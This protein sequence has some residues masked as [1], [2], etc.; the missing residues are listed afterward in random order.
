MSNRFYVEGE[1]RGEKVRDLFSRVAPRY[2]FINDLQSFGLH[3]V[4]KARLTRLAQ[5][6]P[7]EQALDVCCGTGDIAFSLAQAGAHVTALDFSDA[8]LEVAKARARRKLPLRVNFQQGDAQHLPFP[9]NSFDVVSIGYG[10]RNLR[11]WKTGLHEMHRVAKPGARLLILEFG[12]PDNAVWRAWYFAYLRFVV[13]IL[14]KVFCGD[15]A[16][17]SYIL[18]SLQHYPAQHGVAEAMRALG[19]RDV[20]IVNFVGGAMSIQCGLKV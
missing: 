2:D 17:H 20:R 5:V 14:G 16:T 19:C 13:P 8:M 9:D 10:L 4:W 1:E 7:G 11:D 12:K 18:E 6:R 15:S 3:R